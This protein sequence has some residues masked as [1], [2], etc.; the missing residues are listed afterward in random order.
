MEKSFT[1]SQQYNNSDGFQR[2]IWID[3]VKVIACALV[4]LGHLMQSMTTADIL[5]ANSLYEYF[6]KTIYYF[7]VPLFF[8]CSGYL[9]QK[10][11]RINSV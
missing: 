2:E 5:P 10:L 1:T 7:H 9:Y 11:S 6:N 8:I 3:D 4:L